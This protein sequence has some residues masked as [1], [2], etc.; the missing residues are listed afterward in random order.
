MAAL[1]FGVELADGLDLIAEEVDADGPVGLGRVDVQDA[2]ADGELAGHLDDVDAGVADREQMF[3]QHVDQVLFADF[4]REGERGVEVRL[5]EF[6]AGGLNG[7]DDQPRGSGGDLPERGGSRL[8]DLRVRR[9]VFK[10]QDVVSWQ[11][12]NG[13]GVERAGQFTGSEHG[14]VQGLGRFIVGHQNQRGRGGGLHKVGEIERAAG[15]RE[16]GDAPP[17]LSGFQMA[18]DA[19]EGVGVLEVRDEFAN[20][21]EN[22]GVCSS[23]QVSGRFR[24]QAAPVAANPH[25][26]LIEDLRS[27]AANVRERQRQRKWPVR[28]EEE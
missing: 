12:E 13:L 11:A 26:S 18:A 7:R 5:E 21:G 28:S 1:G 27:L 2:A 3:D 15:E 4:E 16:S 17:A 22:H 20:K 14:R 25:F 24:V 6:E 8:L 9:E 23:L 19:V 10:G